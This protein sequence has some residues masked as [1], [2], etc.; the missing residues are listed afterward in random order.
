VFGTMFAISAAIALLLATLGMYA[1]VAYGVSRRPQEIGVRVAL[2]RLGDEHPAAG[3]ASG[4]GARR[5]VSR[6][7]LW[8][9]SE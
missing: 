7:D 8:R 3:V 4:C 1:V 6:S 9:L 5:S 2:G